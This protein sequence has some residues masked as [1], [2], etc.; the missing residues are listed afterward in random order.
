M[1]EEIFDD[2]NTSAYALGLD[3]FEA[4]NWTN[5]SIGLFV[6]KGL[7]LEDKYLGVK[8]NTV[9]LMLISGPKAPKN[10]AP[11]LRVI[12]DEFNKFGPEST[13]MLVTPATL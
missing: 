10:I 6:L 2:T 3:W 1:R 12:A 11:L 9:P 5:H 4:Y 8:S 13:G 7:D